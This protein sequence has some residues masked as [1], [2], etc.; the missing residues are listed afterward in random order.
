MPRISP[1]AADWPELFRSDSSTTVA[2]SRAVERGAIRPLGLGLYTSSLDEPAEAIIARHRWRAG[3]LLAPGAVISYRT[4]L[5]L[6]PEQDGTIFLVG[7]SRY[8]R[9]LPG[10]RIRVTKGPGP[11]PG[12]FDM[13][14]GLKVASRPRA[15][16]EALK[17]SRARAGVARGVRRVDAERILEH[18]FQS[19]GEQAVNRFR[20]EARALAPR[21]T[22]S[23]NSPSSIRCRARSSVPGTAR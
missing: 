22:R 8:E 1:K 23:N 11:Q 18:A 20:D 14:P 7:R 19:G 3:G 16:L 5:Y 10:L 2:V 9:D 13:V 6:E 17:P 12:D 15:L 4:G 21:S